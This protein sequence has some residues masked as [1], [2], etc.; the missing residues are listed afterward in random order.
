MSL[1]LLF[2]LVGA[3]KN[4]VA[5]LNILLCVVVTHYCVLLFGLV[6]ANKNAVAKLNILLRDRVR[7]CDLS[8][9]PVRHTSFTAFTVAVSLDGRHYIGVGKLRCDVSKY[10]GIC[11]FITGA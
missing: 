10:F 6:G 3:N 2:G 11:R 8:E 1:L 4:P 5:K 9:T 7:F